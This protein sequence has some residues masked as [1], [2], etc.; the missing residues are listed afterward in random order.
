[1]NNCLLLTKE[2]KCGRLSES[3]FDLA[4]SSKSNP[5]QNVPPIP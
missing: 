4:I 1:M 3:L 2:L 5:E